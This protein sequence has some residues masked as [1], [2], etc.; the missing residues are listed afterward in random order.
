MAQ[1]KTQ[2][3]PSTPSLRKLLAQC[4][5]R[6]GYVFSAE[7]LLHEGVLERIPE[8]IRDVSDTEFI[9]DEIF[10]ERFERLLTDLADYGRRRSYEFNEESS[11]PADQTAQ[12]WLS[13]D[14]SDLNIKISR[15]KRSEPHLIEGRRLT[16]GECLT[17]LV[18]ESRER[19]LSHS[20]L[21][22]LSEYLDYSLDWLFFGV[23][24]IAKSSFHDTY[25]PSAAIL[26]AALAAGADGSDDASV[27]G[28]QSILQTVSEI[29]AMRGTTTWRGA[30]WN[31]LMN[32]KTHTAHQF[33]SPTLPLCAR[34][35][36]AWNI[37]PVMPE[38]PDLL[39]FIDWLYVFI[40]REFFMLAP[41]PKSDWRQ[42]VFAAISR[43]K[44]KVLLLLGTTAQ[45][46]TQYRLGKAMPS[47]SV[48]K[49]AYFLELIIRRF[50]RNGFLQYIAMVNEE[51]R[52][53]NFTNLLEVMERKSWREDKKAGLAEDFDDDDLEGEEAGDAAGGEAGQ[54]APVAAEAGGTPAA[55]LS[56]PR[57]KPKKDAESLLFP[58]A[59]GGDGEGGADEAIAAMT[60]GETK[61]ATDSEAETAKPARS[62]KASKAAKEGKEGKEGKGSKAGQDAKG[63][64]NAKGAKGSKA[65]TAGKGAEEA[66]DGKT[67]KADK[68][69]KGAVRRKTA[70]A[71]E[72]QE[73]ADQPASQ[74]SGKAPRKPAGQAAGQPSERD[75]EMNPGLN[76]Q[77]P[78]RRRRP[79]PLAGFL[80]RR[81]KAR[82]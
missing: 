38:M 50:G 18:L 20:M 54:D 3:Q 28:M 61:A 60:E 11:D 4:L 36:S 71:G 81:G 51:A 69:G 76:P 2:N 74:P 46:G 12:R 73:P 1:Q 25:D 6:K 32:G 39:A 14:I 13:G 67:A 58:D 63:A 41:L 17:R 30:D 66:N 23:G 52:A 33:K 48:V 82:D 29:K 62:R 49:L 5:Q 75:A 31:W 9:L 68:A 78:V 57:K 34:C 72:A 21:W 80:R 64:K 16:F 79:A 15:G 47:S 37:Q 26:D 35:V 77:Q 42:Q 7:T 70:Q 19:E 55:A 44:N 27:D 59:D 22:W 8:L 65:G 56:R 45:A 24:T 40:L 43:G 53:R 10:G